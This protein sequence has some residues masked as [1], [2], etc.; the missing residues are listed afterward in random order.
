MK[1]TNIYKEILSEGVLDAFR[2][3]LGPKFAQAE[4]SLVTAAGRLFGNRVTNVASLSNLTDDELNQALRAA[5]FKAYRA[6]IAASYI[7]QHDAQINRII[8]RF[9]VTTSQG[10]MGAKAEIANKLNV[11]NAFA[12]EI[13]K[14]KAPKPQ[15]GGGSTGGGNQG[16]GNQGGGNRGGGSRPNLSNRLNTSQMMQHVE[17]DPLFS[18]ILETKKG[19][20]AKLEQY[21]NLNFPN[22]STP[23]ELMNKL[24]PYFENA[25]KIPDKAKSQMLS[26]AFNFF[27]DE[28]GWKLAGR[29][30]QWGLGFALLGVVLNW[31]TVQEALQEIL[32]R[33][34]KGEKARK[35]FGC[36]GPVSTETNPN[37]GVKEKI[38]W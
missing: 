33:F 15:G 5:E 8:K 32:C 26:R 10:R 27:K 16:G 2:A 21:L 36:D 23:D 34:P 22:G 30:A 4:R 28:N 35:Y 29:A 11:K 31:W 9:D 24:T 6:S 19:L 3:L 38:T 7:A 13:F 18:H 17:A 14:A 25:S 12:D 1:L 20:R 37:N